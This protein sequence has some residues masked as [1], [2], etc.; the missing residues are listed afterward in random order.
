MRRKAPALRSIG[1]DRDPRALAEFRCDDAVELVHGCAH[2]F[3]PASGSGA[4]NWS[5]AVRRICT[6]PVGRS[7]GTAP[8]IPMPATPPC[9]SCSRACRAR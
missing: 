6:R 2:E 3:W 4:R 7:G 9:S 1:I 5:T 8:S